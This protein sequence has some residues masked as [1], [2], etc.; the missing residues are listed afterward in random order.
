MLLHL[1]TVY[2]LSEQPYDLTGMNRN[3]R[4]VLNTETQTF[5][6]RANSRLAMA[7]LENGEIVL[8]AVEAAERFPKW[9]SY[10]FFTFGNKPKRTLTTIS[11][12]QDELTFCQSK[13]RVATYIRSLIDEKM[14][15]ESDER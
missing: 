3:W 13:G 2:S 15:D 4:F 14:K 12:T 9:F 5:I 7:R 1:N 11:L 10:Q 6:V 8:S